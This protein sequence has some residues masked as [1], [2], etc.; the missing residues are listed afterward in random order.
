VWRVG[1]WRW[2]RRLF[3]WEEELVGE[4]ILL[5]QNVTLQVNKEDSWHWIL[6]SSKIFYVR[7]A[8]K[9]LTGQLPI[10][11]SVPVSSL[12]HKDV[13]LKV[14]LFAWRLF[15]NRLPTNYN[16]FRQGVIDQNSLKCVAGCDTVE[17]SEHL[18]LH[19]NWFGSVWYLIYG[20]L[21]T[22]T[23]A[24]H[25]LTDHFSY[26]VIWYATGGKSEKKEITDCFQTKLARW[27]M[28]WISLSPTH[29]CGWRWSLLI[30]LLIF[31]DGGLTRLQCWT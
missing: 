17:S 23:A 3:V 7:S 9:F 15:R 30:F 8:Y 5:L 26:I 28:W 2:R 4:L 24:P 6:E 31:M 1:A 10:A 29:L 11:T 20:W 14:V 19:C 12:W 27:H 16:L 21:G 22:Y 18:F 25:S 13:P